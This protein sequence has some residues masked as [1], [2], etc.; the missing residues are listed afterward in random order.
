[1][2]TPEKT[3]PI[4]QDELE[5][6]S[7]WFE[8]TKKACDQVGLPAPSEGATVLFVCESISWI[9]SQI[10]DPVPFHN[11][12]NRQL[13]K[14]ILVNI[15][16][17]HTYLVRSL[18]HEIKAQGVLKAFS[19]DDL[20]SCC[21]RFLGDALYNGVTFRDS[22]ALKTMGLK[23]VSETGSLTY[24]TGGNDEHTANDKDETCAS[25]LASQ[26]A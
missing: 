7:F 4:S 20:L 14:L 21:V 24:R 25:S 9:K 8:W 16:W 5:E 26:S 11:M 13:I 22:A 23:A 10:G 19:D 6:I 2:D 3:P 15:L 1:M 12:K 17:E 18:F